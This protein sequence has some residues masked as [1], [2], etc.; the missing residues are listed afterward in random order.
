MKY[1]KDFFQFKKFN[2]IFEQQAQEDEPEDDPAPPKGEVVKKE[3]K[4]TP[5]KEKLGDEDFEV[6]ARK[7]P[8]KKLDYTKKY[9]SEEFKDHP[10]N[11]AGGVR[12]GK[13]GSNYATM[14]IP[15]VNKAFNDLKTREKMVQFLKEYDGQDKETVQRMI[16]EE[17]SKNGETNLWKAMLK[18][19]TDGKVGPYHRIV[20]NGMIENKITKLEIP[21][22]KVTTKP[23]P[24]DGGTTTGDGE[25]DEGTNVIVEAKSNNKFDFIKWTEEGKDVSTD[26]KFTF[27]ITSSR[28]L[29]AI[30][31]KQD[32][33]YE[34]D[35]HDDDVKG[36]LGEKSETI[37]PKRDQRLGE[38]EKMQLSFASGGTS[39]IEKLLSLNYPSAE[40]K[41]IL[42]NLSEEDEKSK[43]LTAK[44]GRVD[45][46][47]DSIDGDKRK[48]SFDCISNRND[49]LKGELYVYVFYK[50]FKTLNS[51]Q[52]T[53][54]LGILRRKMEGGKT[55]IQFE[56]NGKDFDENEF[57]S[58]FVANVIF[59]SINLNI[60]NKQFKDA[61]NK[62][63]K[64]S[65]SDTKVKNLFT[66]LTTMGDGGLLV[67]FKDTPHKGPLY[68]T[69]KI[70][71]TP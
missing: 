13:P 32:S 43:N 71:S 28:N 49:D 62:P 58:K 40:P 5:Y 63:L 38:Q 35:E 2:R 24:E 51:G 53:N 56:L 12:N 67:L 30:F 48:I 16:Q 52:D 60:G 22:Y 4:E 8:K 61:P 23:E 29:I 18:H 3:V 33:K 44:L 47:T 69:Q 57:K 34:E 10:W 9:D 26:S 42:L 15:D 54:D 11:G 45:S 59:S 6:K 25:Y 66:E 31:K 41:D 27:V 39:N 68:S 20:W 46:V 7:Q 50:R 37:D 17:V 64:I 1:F 55:K 14:W 21:K 36:G 65:S 70:T 19:A